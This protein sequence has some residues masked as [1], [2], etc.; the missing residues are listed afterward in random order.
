MTIILNINAGGNSALEKFEKIK[1]R[2]HSLEKADIIS[3]RN[4]DTVDKL[5]GDSIKNGEFQF[6]AAGGDGTVNCLL[7]SIMHYVPFE[8]IER[9]ILGAIGLGSSNDFHK[10]FNSQIDGI[11]YSIDF[12]NYYE[13]DICY[14]D[15]HS[16]GKI[17]RKYFL[18]NA[19]IGLTALGNYYYNNRNLLVKYVSKFNPA[20][21][22][23]YSIF[24]T[25]LK[26]RN[27]PVN[28]DQESNVPRS[29]ALSN[30][31]VL[32]NPHFS[33]DLKYNAQIDYGNG[34]FNFYLCDRMNKLDM[35]KLLASLQ[36]GSTGNI[37][38][39]STWTGSSLKISSSSPFWCE[40]DG[41]VIKT[42]SISF[43]ILNKKLKVCR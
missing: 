11:P 21:S 20:V 41:E 2:V 4:K 24:K 43:G 9:I 25:L 7:N 14:L 42:D 8:Q 32:K 38:K 6:A 39:L 22:I 18:I 16:N 1:S 19:S 33:A 13:R 35:I 28:I 40:Y 31:A 12:N 29:I 15:Y 5:I 17:K 27:I 30:L 34:L 26:F 3:E 10:P 23:Y 36:K 37:H